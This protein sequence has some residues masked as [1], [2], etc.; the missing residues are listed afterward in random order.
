MAQSGILTNIQAV[1]DALRVYGL[2]VKK[3][4]DLAIRNKMGDIALRAAKNTYFRDG[5]VI[6]S[7]LSNLPIT[8]DGGKARTGATQWVGLY[9]LIN[10]ERKQKGMFPL[11]NSRF[12]KVKKFSIKGPM[13]MMKEVKK[14]NIPRNMGPAAATERF[15]DGRTKK[16]LQAR[17]RSSKWLRVGWA[18]A[19]IFFGKK[20]SRG[21][22]GPLTL[23]RISG[24]AYGHAEV[25]QFG[26][27]LTEYIMTNNAGKYDVRKRKEGEE[28]APERSSKDQGRAAAIIETGLNLG[29]QEAFADIMKYFETRMPRVRAAMAQIN[30]LR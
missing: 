30:K 12:R 3:E 29:L 13:A 26:G 28:Y 23:S 24:E 27:D 11:G 20:P 25:K 4:T 2:V 19:A 7:Q 15:M 5:G 22:F 18:K 8:K 14:R 10:W 17:Q 21:D 6:R 1:Q 16:F 9:K